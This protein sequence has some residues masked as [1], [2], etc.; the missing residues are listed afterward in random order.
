M[1]EFVNPS[2]L[3]INLIRYIG[4]RVSETGKPIAELSDFSSNIGAPSDLI[5]EDI[6][7]ELLEK[8]LVRAINQNLYAGYFLNVNLGLEGWERYEAEKRGSLSGNLGF[9]A[10]KFNDPELDSFV[11][12]VVKPATKEI[13]YDLVDMRDVARAG[14]IDNIMRTQIRDSAFVIVDLGSVL[15]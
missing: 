13:G 9:I 14:V 8:K 4:D 11:N 3:T 6:F 2:T 12:D 15:D 7:R 1:P 10:M 5:S